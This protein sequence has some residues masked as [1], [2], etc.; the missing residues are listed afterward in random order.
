M[1]N[2]KTLNLKNRFKKFYFTKSFKQK[3]KSNT[4]FSGMMEAQSLKAAQPF[5]NEEGRFLNKL[6]KELN[7]KG[8]CYSYTGIGDPVA[9]YADQ[10]LPYCNKYLCVDPLL[11][12]YQKDQ[13]NNKNYLFENKIKYYNLEF[14]KLPIRKN[15][16][17]CKE[18]YIFTFVFNLISY[19]PNPL[20]KIQKMVQPGD[21]ITYSVW[22]DNDKA[23]KVRQYYLQSLQNNQMLELEIKHQDKNYMIKN[24]QDIVDSCLN[25][26]KEKVVIHGDVIDFVIIYL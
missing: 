26:I 15:A 13:A 2:T 23:K 7:A 9:I 18:N 20:L 4:V 16:V 12:I 24:H 8:D 19:L 11:N 10:I 6:I 14:Q 1:L 17:K 22:S 3:E 5:L 21:I 25:N